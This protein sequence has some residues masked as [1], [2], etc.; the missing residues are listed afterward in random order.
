MLA[1]PFLQVLDCK[2]GFNLQDKPQRHYDAME[3]KLDLT[4]ENGS[5]SSIVFWLGENAFKAMR[6]SGEFQD[7]QRLGRRIA[8][9]R[10]YDIAEGPTRACLEAIGKVDAL[11]S[12]KACLLVSGTLTT[13]A[14]ACEFFEAAHAADGSSAMI[15][16]TVSIP[17]IIGK[18]FLQ[19]TL[20]K[21]EKI[22]GGFYLFEDEQS[23][24]AYLSSESWAT[25]CAAMPWEDVK[26]DRYRVAAEAS[27][28]A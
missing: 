21:E 23:L 5:Q 18:I 25:T 20:G 28:S 6:A 16:E 10:K 11:P 8:K 9:D 14:K 4:A 1:S 13:G 17:G 22:V 2:A 12:S 15:Q 19:G 26:T 24:D 27:A 3:H 7:K